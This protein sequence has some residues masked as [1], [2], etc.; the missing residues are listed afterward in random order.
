MLLEDLPTPSLLLD[1]DILESNIRF[2]QDRADALGVRMRPHV[3][4][5][6]CIEIGE[7]QR[8]AGATGITVATIEEDFTNQRS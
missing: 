7:L 8:S 6:K 3:K 5:H 1:L 4:T 2:M